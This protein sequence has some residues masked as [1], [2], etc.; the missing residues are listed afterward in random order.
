MARPAAK[1]IDPFH[2]AATP[3]PLLPDLGLRTRVG[4]SADDPQ[5][6]RHRDLRFAV[7]LT[8]Y[9][10]DGRRVRR[11]RIGRLEPGQRRFFDLSALVERD[12]FGAPHLCAVHRVPEDL[13][14]E[15]DTAS[16][17]VAGG[18][19]AD[20]DMYRSVVQLEHPGGGRGSVIYEAPPRF[21]ADP[22]RKGAF[23]GFSNQAVVGAGSDSYL[24][25]LFYSTNPGLA[26]TARRRVLVYGPEGRLRASDERSV[27]AFQ[28]DATRFG[29]LV[30][31]ADE[32]E[33]RQY[34]FVA[35]SGDASMATLILNLNPRVGGVSLEHTH[36]PISYLG[37]PMAQATAR[38]QKAIAH[39]LSLKTEAAGA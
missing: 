5:G 4:L 10:P 24:L 19:D 32:P 2:L 8:V 1:R 38:R 15:A 9:A 14:V 29:A 23:L 39:F 7:W 34:S 25:L 13:A 20:F 22:S 35:C 30:G 18:Y 12:A 21:N 28:L 31:G 33:L 36:A 6:R 17:E 11:E 27:G 3:V 26:A 16:L 37:M